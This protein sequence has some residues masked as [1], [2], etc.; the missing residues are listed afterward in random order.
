MT[1]AKDELDLIVPQRFYTYQQSKTGDRH[2]YAGRSRFIPE[3]IMDSFDCHS[4][5][6]RMQGSNRAA[7]KTGSTTDVAASLRWMWR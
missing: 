7:T 3:G 2:V 5:H 6:E 1:R 4:W